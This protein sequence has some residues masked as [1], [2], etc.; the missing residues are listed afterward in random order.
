MNKRSIFLSFL[1]II[2]VSACAP[3]PTP[4]T[5]AVPPT[6]TQMPGCAD[7]S[8]YPDNTRF[9][10]PFSLNGYQFTGT[11]PGGEPFVNFSGSVVGLQFSTP[12]LEIDLPGP[13]SSINLDVVSF[14]SRP[15]SLAALDSSGTAIASATVP[16]DNTVH[17]ITL[18]GA[19]IVKVTIQ[20]SDN[21][22]NLVVLCMQ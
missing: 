21:E 20:G 10:N 18:S 15:L 9:G 13:A 19:S 14:T 11:P 1:M 3:A 8:G 6:P 2:L 22:A 4:P 17:N 12:G 16:G 7:F 5:P